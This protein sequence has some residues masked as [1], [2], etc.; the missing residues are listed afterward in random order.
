MKGSLA[1]TCM[2]A[3]RVLQHDRAELLDLNNVRVVNKLLI[4]S[5]KIAELETGFRRKTVSLYIVQQ[6]VW[7]GR[8][9]RELGRTSAK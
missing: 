9:Q 6:N 5:D 2:T 1:V 8:A 3:E 7:E 4:A